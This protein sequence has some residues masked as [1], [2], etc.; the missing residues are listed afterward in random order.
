MY[1]SLCIVQVVKAECLI[2]QFP[3]TFKWDVLY[4]N[5]SIISTDHR[6]W[7]RI[8]VWVFNSHVNQRKTVLA[9]FIYHQELSSISENHVPRGKFTCTRVW[10]LDSILLGDI[11]SCHTH[12][13]ITYIYRYTYLT[14]VLNVECEGKSAFLLTVALCCQIWA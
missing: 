4:R 8:N 14:V 11:F 5:K 1:Q 12:S 2:T 13:S 6:Y 7:H 3:V 9:M 10:Q